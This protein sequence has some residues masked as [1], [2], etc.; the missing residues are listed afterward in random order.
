MKHSWR[1]WFPSPRVAIVA[2][3]L[4][5]ATVWV[6][7]RPTNTQPQI[8]QDDIPVLENMDV[9]SNFDVLTE[10]PPPAQVDDGGQQQN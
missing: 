4:V 7:T 5:V 6:S 9:L 2:A 10:L 3:A 8:A 1:A